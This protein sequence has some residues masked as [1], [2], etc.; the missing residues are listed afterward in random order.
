MSASGRQLRERAMRA[1]A[2]LE[3]APA[4]R[5]VGRVKG[6]HKEHVPRAICIADP[7][8]LEL[9]ADALLQRI[10]GNARG[11]ANYVFI[12]DGLRAFVISDK[13]SVVRT[14]E[15]EHLDWLVGVYATARGADNLAEDIA[16]HLKGY[17]AP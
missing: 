8:H 5:R 14:W 6:F 1:A 10:R 4:G 15:R 17:T 11:F 9:T 16:E 7:A 12:D 13:Q 3:S 2:A